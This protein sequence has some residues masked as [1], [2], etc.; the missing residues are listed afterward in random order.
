MNQS[1]SPDPEFAT[2]EEAEAY[3]RWFREQVE[4]ALADPGPSIPH[5]Q[6]MEEMFALIDV[7]RAQR[8]PKK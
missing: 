8:K 2:P 6:V 4:L 5:E 1:T 7:R 3:E